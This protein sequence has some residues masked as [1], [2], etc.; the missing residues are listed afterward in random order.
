MVVRNTNFFY[1]VQNSLP[2]G[3]SSCFLSSFATN[4]KIYEQTID[5]GHEG[6]KEA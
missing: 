6:D 5:R 1:N 3:D 2:A 4:H